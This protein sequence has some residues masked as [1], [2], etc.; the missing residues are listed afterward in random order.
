[1]DEFGES[2]LCTW[3]DGITTTVHFVHKNLCKEENGY[4]AILSSAGSK[5][6]QSVR[7]QVYVKRVYTC[8]KKKVVSEKGGVPRA[9]R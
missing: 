2:Y 3:K 4:Q 9:K 5:N 6:V 1:M 8:P 7:V